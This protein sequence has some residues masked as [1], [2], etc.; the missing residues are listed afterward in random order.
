[1]DN[2]LYDILGI[3][4]DATQ[5]Q[6]RKAYKKKALKTHPDRL[7]QGATASDK[8]LSEEQ[9]RK[10]CMPSIRHLSQHTEQPL[11]QVNNA[12]EILNDAQNRKV[13]SL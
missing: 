11:Q 7:P 6:V 13:S 8:A 2:N 1:M 4:S 9:F 12:Y 5:E 3:D 10:V